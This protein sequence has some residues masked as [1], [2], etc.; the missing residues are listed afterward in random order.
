MDIIRLLSRAVVGPFVLL[1]LG[2]AVLCAGFGGLVVAE[3]GLM[4]G[5]NRPISGNVRMAI[6][7]QGAVM[8]L[9]GTLLVVRSG[10]VGSRRN[11]QE[12]GF[13]RFYG[14][15][16]PRSGE[17]LQDFKVSGGNSNPLQSMWADAA[18]G[19]RVCPR[20][21]YNGQFL[22]VEFLNGQNASPCRVVI[23]SMG[24]GPLLNMPGRKYLQF[25]ARVPTCQP[26][27]TRPTSQNFQKGQE[28]PSGAP[29]RTRR[30]ALRVRVV[31]GLLQHWIW[32]GRSQAPRHL[33]VE[34]QSW[35]TFKLPLG[36]GWSRFRGE[37]N[38][39][40]PSRADFEVLSGVVFEV[41][42]ETPSAAGAYGL[43]DIRD[44]RCAD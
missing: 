16:M 23:R 44:I 21:D 2:L 35:K 24:D 9:V 11:A 32:Q 25:E 42:E 7:A 43:V 41:G 39:E 38:P 13:Y 5:L 17:Q 31:N 18:A 37:G 29:Q 4:P 27:Y 22:R 30:V 10:R 36:E 40:G 26:K 14:L 1:I 8:F 3:S 33:V 19:S 20:L 12:S 34:G 6:G 15:N 28:P